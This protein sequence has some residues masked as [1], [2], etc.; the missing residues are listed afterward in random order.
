MDVWTGYIP[1][2]AKIQK[3]FPPRAGNIALPKPLNAHLSMHVDT[4]AFQS[5]K[6]CLESHALFYA[7]KL[8]ER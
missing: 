7:V 2:R 5:V 3:C 4:G 1:L 8:P 6:S